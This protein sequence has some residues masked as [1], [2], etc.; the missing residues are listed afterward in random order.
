MI[1]WNSR[2]T[3]LPA[4]IK[5]CWFSKNPHHFIAAIN[6]CFCSTVQ[7]MLEIYL[8]Q[9]CLQRKLLVLPWLLGYYEPPILQKYTQFFYLLPGRATMRC[10][11]YSWNNSY[12]LTHMFLSFFRSALCCLMIPFLMIKFAWTVLL[13]GTCVWDLVTLSGKVIDFISDSSC[14]IRGFQGQFSR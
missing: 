4:G 13:D 1:G 7:P 2:S 3:W 10:P 11:K 12:C 14:I 6:C 8:F 9:F 5:M